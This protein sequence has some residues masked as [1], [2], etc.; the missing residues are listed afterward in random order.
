MDSTTATE[1]AGL[2]LLKALVWVVYAL[3]SI[4]AIFLAFSFALHIADASTKS[5]FVTFVYQTAG[6]FAG[7]FVG[8]LKSTRLANGGIVSWSAL[9]AIAAY[10]VAAW[11]VGGVLRAISH[12]IYRESHPAITQAKETG[13]AE[14]E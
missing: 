5:S 4:A 11:A 8:M 9:F 3:A 7:P 10:A 6:L 14:A 12:S 1:V 2:R 13:D